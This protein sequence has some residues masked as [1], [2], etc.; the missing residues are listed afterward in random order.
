[1]CQNVVARVRPT[2]GSDSTLSS[3][4][5][6]SLGPVPVPMSGVVTSGLPPDTCRPARQLSTMLAH[7]FPLGRYYFYSQE[8]LDPLQEGRDL[9]VSCP[10]AT[11]TQDINQ[12]RIPSLRGQP[13]PNSFLR[14][15]FSFSRKRP[16]TRH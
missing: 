3:P 11:V 7:F 5:F 1:M 9:W 13:F 8:A 16:S 14:K 15:D 4:S 2:L 6:L 10:K 12:T